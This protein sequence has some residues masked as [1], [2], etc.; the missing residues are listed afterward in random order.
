MTTLVI[1]GGQLITPLEQRFAN[2]W[3]DG[4]LIEALT[5]KLPGNGCQQLDASNCYVTPGLFDLQVNG[6]PSCNLWADPGIV[7]LKNLCGELAANGTTSFLPTLITD[8][9]KHLK[10]NL[11]FL[12]ENGAGLQARLPQAADCDQAYK[13]QNVARMVGVHL[14]G[15][16]LSAQRPGVHPAQWLQPLSV[17][18]MRNLITEAVKLVTLAP[19]LEASGESIAYLASQGIKVALGHSNATFEQAQH[20]FECGVDMVTHTFNALP[21][22]HHRAAGA[23]TAALLD[24]QVSCCLICDGLHLG[25]SIVQLVLQAK[26]FKKSILVSDAA[27]AGTSQ[28][29]LVGS[30]IMLSQAVCNVVKWGAASFAEA[31]CMA[32]WNPAVSL[33]VQESI[34]HLHPGKF[35]D[36]VIWDKES[37]E[38]KHVIVGGKYLEGQ[39]G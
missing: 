38:I 5:S 21:P 12:Q 34:G 6:S 32:S 16:C 2:L 24:K 31:I 13:S 39:Q 33:N 17:E 10:K 8:E 15:P 20:A 3:I 7:E 29:G 30:S 14:E 22:I 19:E 18:L 25:P 35:A 27:H 1:T 26:G 23:V 28:G 9:V 36:L 37:L 11:A 4:Q